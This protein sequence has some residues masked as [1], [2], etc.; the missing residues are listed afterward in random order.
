MKLAKGKI[1]VELDEIDLGLIDQ[2]YHEQKYIST[3]GVVRQVGDL[4]IEYRFAYSDTAYRAS[5]KVEVGDKVLLRW[6][7]VSSAPTYEMCVVLDYRSVIAVIHGEELSLRNGYILTAENKVVN[8]SYDT[9][10]PMPKVGDYVLCRRDFDVQYIGKYDN[11][12][13]LEQTDLIAWGD[14]T[15]SPKIELV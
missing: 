6:L 2:S 7:Y 15:L 9:D 5:K 12:R 3:T 1:L 14:V 10:V 8:V 13:F 11:L 4:E